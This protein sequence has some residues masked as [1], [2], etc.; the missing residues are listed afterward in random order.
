[1]RTSATSVLP[2]AV[3]ASASSRVQ[4]EHLSGEAA[5]EI[6]D[7]DPVNAIDA[8]RDAVAIDMAGET[9]GQRIVLIAQAR[10]VQAQMDLALAREVHVQDGLVERPGIAGA[11]II[12][13]QPAA[14]HLDP[15]LI[16][17]VEFPALGGVGPAGG[18][19][20]DVGRFLRDDPGR[21]LDIVELAS[22]VRG[23]L[24]AVLLEL[25][26]DM[27]DVRARGCILGGKQGRIQ[28][29]C[30]VREAAVQTRDRDP[31][32][33]VDAQGDAVAV[34]VTQEFGGKRGAFVREV[35]VIQSQLDAALAREVHVENGLVQ[36]GGIAGAGVIQPQPAANDLNAAGIA[37]II[38]PALGGAGR[39][40]VKA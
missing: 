12:H 16:L 3:L 37:G 15:A 17:R 23:R 28:R 35:G 29:E 10:V 25:D 9:G 22:I 27:G 39:P 32:H 26:P 8:Q 20:L 1:M 2:A 4:R 14:G 31:M 38:S 30:L 24:V 11:G 13:P 18:E 34:V 36:R 33:S 5:R 21:D 40:A 7:A 6:P 19:V